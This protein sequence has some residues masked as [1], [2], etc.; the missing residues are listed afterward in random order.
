MAW[1]VL[2]VAALLELVWATAL[3]HS[4]GLS[5]LWPS[6]AALTVAL[7]SVVLL[8][9]ALRSLPVGTAYAAWV[10]VGAAGVFLAGVVF[11]KE[12]ASPLRIG[13]VALIVLG[14]MG[15]SLVEG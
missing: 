10:G 3:K 13:F 6:V 15:L 1:A 2:I 14:V 5:R 4:D 12:E 11:L 7:L 9:M 8:S